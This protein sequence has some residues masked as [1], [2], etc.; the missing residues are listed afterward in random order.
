MLGKPMLW[1]IY[2]QQD[3]A[4]LVK[5]EAFLALYLQAAAPQ[6]RQSLLAL[7]RCWN[8]PGLPM[9][10]LQPLLA[11]SPQDWQQH[12]GEWQACCSWEIWRQIWCNRWEIGYS[13]DRLF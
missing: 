8:Q 4:H 5:L 7:F 13:A 10:D 12:A 1:H 11:D 3:D 9:P 2:Q 6:L